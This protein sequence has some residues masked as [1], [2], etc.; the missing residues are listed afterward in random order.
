MKNLFLILPVLVAPALAQTGQQ[1]AANPLST[2][3]RDAYM[4]N[5]NTIV[6]TAEKMPE[7]N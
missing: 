5:R 7:E 1:P 2:W 3:L 4:R 6:R